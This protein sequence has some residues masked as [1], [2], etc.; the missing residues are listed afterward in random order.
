[1]D[2]QIMTYHKDGNLQLSCKKKKSHFDSSCACTWTLL[3][4]P[5]LTLDSL[6]QTDSLHKP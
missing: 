3:R 5:P 1:M 6:F 4:A 2:K